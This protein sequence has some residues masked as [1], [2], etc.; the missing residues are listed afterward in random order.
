MG[1]RGG[2]SWAFTLGM[3][4]VSEVFKSN[5]V[6]VLVKLYA[7]IRT[8]GENDESTRTIKV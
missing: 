6:L 2:F 4:F 1:M 3:H 7:E 5:N 8:L